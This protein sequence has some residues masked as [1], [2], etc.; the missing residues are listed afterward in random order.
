MGE[1]GLICPR[2]YSKLKLVEKAG[3]WF[4]RVVTLNISCYLKQANRGW[5]HA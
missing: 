3:P 2:A 5:K 1:N 4:Q